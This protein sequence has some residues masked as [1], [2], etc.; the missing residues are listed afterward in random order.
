MQIRID[1]LL[2]GA[3]RATGAV[4]II[5]VFR[6]FSTAAVAL[7]RKRWVALVVLG[8][9]LAVE[10]LA[11]VVL[12]RVGRSALFDVVGAN[13]R[14]Q[15]FDSVWD[16]VTSSLVTQTIILGVI[17]LAAAGAGVFAHMREEQRRRPEAWA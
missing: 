1:S 10:A 9:G 16:T 3:E 17:G 8:V 5:D 11:I 7:A 2:A 4:V 14:E 15:T 12:L 6:A 13:V